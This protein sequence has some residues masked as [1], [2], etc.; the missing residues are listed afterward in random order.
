MFLGSMANFR[1][2]EEGPTGR[3]IAVKRVSLAEGIVVNFELSAWHA[4]Q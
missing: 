3:G 4:L 2:T 1:P